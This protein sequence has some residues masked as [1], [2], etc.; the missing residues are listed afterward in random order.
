VRAKN[1]TFICFV[2]VVRYLIITPEI[3]SVDNENLALIGLQ[4]SAAS[5]RGV[6]FLLS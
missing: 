5:I 3:L 1:I 4:K 2:G 6:P